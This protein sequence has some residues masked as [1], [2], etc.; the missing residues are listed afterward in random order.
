MVRLIGG[1]C[2]NLDVDTSR[3]GL[4]LTTEG[5]TTRM[6]VAKDGRWQSYEVRG[7]DVSSAVFLGPEVRT[8]GEAA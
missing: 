8:W 2:H 6:L 5:T 7:D 3:F 4:D 1:H